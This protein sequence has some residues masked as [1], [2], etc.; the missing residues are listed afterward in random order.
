M[1][2]S[3]RYVSLPRPISQEYRAIGS[4]ILLGVRA[5]SSAASMPRAI[6]AHGRPGPFRLDERTGDSALSKSYCSCETHPP[7][8]ITRAWHYS[9][10]YSVLFLAIRS[11]SFDPGAGV[12]SRPSAS[13]RV[14][15]RS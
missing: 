2:T 5:A 6:R 10:A 11:A 8:H 3:L 1:A 9:R 13:M 4:F 15:R 12:S 14:S 7:E